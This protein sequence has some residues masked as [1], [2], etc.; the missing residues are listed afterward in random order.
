MCSLYT[1]GAW[2]RNRKWTS[3][4]HSNVISIPPILIARKLYT[5][6]E[7]L[8]ERDTHVAGVGGNGQKLRGSGLKKTLGCAST[9]TRYPISTPIISAVSFCLWRHISDNFWN[10]AIK[11]ISNWIQAL[12]RTYVCFQVLSRPWIHM[13]E[14]QVLSRSVGTLYII[15][16]WIGTTFVSH[17]QWYTRFVKQQQKRWYLVL[18]L[19]TIFVIVFIYGLLKGPPDRK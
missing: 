12:S 16:Y 3:S 9:H 18:C 5:I 7:C 13:S 8:W 17:L 11:F 10:S 4:A 15:L 19:C 6:L 2:S 1:E 14:I